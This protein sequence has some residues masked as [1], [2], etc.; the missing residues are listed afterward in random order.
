MI[1]LIIDLILIAVFLG[2]CIAGAVKG[3][4]KMIM[5]VFGKLGAF[6]VACIFSD[7]LSAA[8]N[9]KYFGPYFS[10]LFAKYADTIAQASD[11]KVAQTVEE[12]PAAFKTMAQML[13]YN[14]ETLVEEIRMGE[15]VSGVVNSLAS[16]IAEAVSSAV[17]F[18]VLFFGILIIAWIL[19]KVL[20]TL[21]KLPVLKTM[22]RWLGFAMGAVEGVFVVCV[23]VLIFSLVLP[24][25][26]AENLLG[27]ADVAVEEIRLFSYINDNNPLAAVFGAIKG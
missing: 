19:T 25:L 21:A 10:E 16:P 23:L 22:N 7:D 6:I 8:I 4:V 3:F 26:Q 11:D 1:P 24:Y 9:S 14:T 27:L 13:G 5:R 17:A 2:L 20:D 18:S 12:L 15:G